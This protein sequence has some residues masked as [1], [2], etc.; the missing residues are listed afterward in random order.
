MKSGIMGIF[1]RGKKLLNAEPK[2]INYHQ[3]IEGLKDLSVDAR[4]THKTD[5]SHVYINAIAMIEG[6]EKNEQTFDALDNSFIV[7][8]KEAEGEERIA[9]ARCASLLRLSSS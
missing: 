6:A 8:S 1:G 5:T 9:W 7:L 4:Y 2:K 3:L